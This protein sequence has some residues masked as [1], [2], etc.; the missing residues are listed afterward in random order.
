M[1]SKLEN[2]KKKIL[3]LNYS[4]MFIYLVLISLSFIFFLPIIRMVSM[5]FMSEADLISP[6]VNWVPTSLTFTNISVAIRVLDY[7]RSLITSILFIGVLSLV[8]TI[9]TGLAGFVFVR[10]NFKFKKALYALI[11]VTFV[12]PIQLFLIQRELTFVAFTDLTGLRMIGTMNPQLLF[13]LLG[14]G[15]NS[16]IIILIFINFFR[17]VPFEL[18]EAA[19]IDGASALQ[20]FWHVT[21]K[22]SFA[23]VMV[24]FVFSFVWHWNDT[25]ITKTFLGDDF[26][27][28]N[29]Q[30]GNFDSLFGNRGGSANNI[31]EAYKMAATLLT[32]APVLI[33]YF[34]TQKQFV[35]GIE[36]SGLTGQ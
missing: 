10:Y 6:E 17:K 19:S 20:T 5:T 4:N 21:L 26:K 30:L 31:N 18:F 1:N 15:V 11:I 28:L 24:A 23:T 9:V 3:K 32:M 35:Q 36:N 29:H 33:L 14:Q 27:L 7:F 8:Q 13:A 16:S 25:I 22:I 34:V 12:V 2:I